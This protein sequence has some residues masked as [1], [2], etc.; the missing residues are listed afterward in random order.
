[1]TIDTKKDSKSDFLVEFD[2]FVANKNIKLTKNQ[3]AVSELLMNNA[4]RGFLINKATGKTFLFRLLDE[5]F[6]SAE[7]LNISK[8]T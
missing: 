1:M 7:F 3:R 5:F 2:K 8:N 6:S 4:D